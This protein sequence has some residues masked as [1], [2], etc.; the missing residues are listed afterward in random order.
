[1]NLFP[2]FSTLIGDSQD[3]YK[4]PK[5][6]SKQDCPSQEKPTLGDLRSNVLDTTWAWPITSQFKDVAIYQCEFQDLKAIYKAS[7]RAM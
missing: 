5:T 7:V 2:L 3:P 4:G 1:M 6:A